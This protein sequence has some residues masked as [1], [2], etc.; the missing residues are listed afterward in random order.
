MS[1]VNYHFK[2]PMQWSIHP[3]FHTNLL[4]PYHE[5][6]THG[7]NYQCPLPDL[8]DREEEYKVEKILDSRW[9]GR[10]HKLQYLIKWIGYPDSENQ[11]VNKDDISADKALQEFKTLNPASEVHV[12]H[13]YIPKDGIITS[14][15][16]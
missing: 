13:L 16:K 15:A 10:R 12:R 14:T 8:V 9:F 3:V 4:T 7:P 1:S 5:T 6:P 2:L 11:W